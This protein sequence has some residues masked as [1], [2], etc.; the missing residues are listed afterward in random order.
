MSQQSNTENPGSI[1]VGYIKK[2]F[3]LVFP[4]IQLWVDNRKIERDEWLS[5]DEEK[6]EKYK[7]EIRNQLSE[8]EEDLDKVIS[9]VEKAYQHELDRS[10]NFDSKAE[11]YVGNVGV[12][13]SILSLAPILAVVFGIS[14][15]DNLTGDWLVAVLLLI[16]GYSVIS[17]F[18]SAYYSTKAMKIRGY[19]VFYTISRLREGFENDGYSRVEKA[20]L[21]LCF[22]K[23]NQERNLEKM[24][25]VSTAEALSRNGLIALGLGIVLIGLGTFA[26]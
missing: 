9:D 18:S 5:L 7:S 13:L 4:P 23:K 6:S 15:D 1:L 8:S 19:S 16:F 10:S 2:F 11:N 20:A 12:V 25:N 21:L 14:A 26:F 24:N 3:Y 22:T 17:L